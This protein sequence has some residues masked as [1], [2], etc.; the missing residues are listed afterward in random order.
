MRHLIY[1]VPDP[2]LP[3]LGV[4]F[5]RTLAA[6][7]RRGRTPCSRS[8]AT[9]IG[10]GVLGTWAASRRPGFWRMARRYWPVGVAELYRSLNDRA[11]ARALARLVPGITDTDLRPIPA[12]VRAQAVARDGTCSTTSCCARPAVVHVLNAPSPAATA[13]LVI[14]ESIATRALE[15]L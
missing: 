2:E 7:S 11:L 12:G 3:F 6:R 5:S 9:G 15:R 4:H 8:A 13:S 10:V 1:P 14:G